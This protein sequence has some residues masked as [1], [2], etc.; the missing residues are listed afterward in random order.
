MEQ[1]TENQVQPT[2]DQW[3]VSRVEW[4]DAG[5]GGSR[6]A[7]SGWRVCAGATYIGVA[8]IVAVA[9]L[10]NAF[11]TADDLTRAGRL[12]RAW[13]PFVWEGSSAV[14][15][16]ALL[17]LPRQAAGLAAGFVSRRVRSGVVVTALAVIGLALAFSALHI[18]GMVLLREFAY[19]AAGAVYPF[20]WSAGEVIYELR[21]DLFSFSIIAVV[22]WL[23]GRAFAKSAL[24]KSAFT[25]P[26]VTQPDFTG[27]G[28][29]ASMP[30]GSS[31]AI[32]VATPVEPG[33]A[34]RLWLRD[35]RTSIL[36]DAG[37]ILWITSAGNYV[38]YVMAT[39]ERHLIRTT[40]QA[41]AQRLAA[42]GIERIHRTRLV[43]IGRIVA[44]NWRPSGDFDLRLDNGE[45]V[46]GS[47]RYRAAVAGIGV[48]APPQAAL[49]RP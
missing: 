13:E 19:A 47:R 44:I 49:L 14:V 42:L 37:D 16:I 18:G 12:Y 46:A 35:G 27:A 11:S 3:S 24:V 6:T 10:V 43:N 5:P 2:R 8:V 33:A 38:E 17:A 21:K 31:E 4:R 20:H 32:A 34:S 39:G 48:P 41:Q 45:T 40:L 1:A 9:C 29:I 22:F 28:P 15:I 23:A 26:A 30:A 25:T 36:V 7:P